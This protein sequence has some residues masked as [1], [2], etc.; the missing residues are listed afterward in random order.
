M[1]V[2]VGIL[3]VCFRHLGFIQITEE[4]FQSMIEGVHVGGDA[5]RDA[6]AVHSIGNEP[7]YETT[8][9]HERVTFGVMRLLDLDPQFE[10]LHHEQ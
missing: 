6:F 2:S 7:L 10:E 3:Y 4:G 1:S 9:F 5:V 8:V